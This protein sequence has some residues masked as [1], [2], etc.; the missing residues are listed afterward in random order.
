MMQ[1]L[2]QEIFVAQGRMELFIRKASFHLLPSEFK[3]N[4][5]YLICKLGVRSGSSDEFDNDL[6]QVNEIS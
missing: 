3:I 4:V 1:R 6:I 2:N 5:T